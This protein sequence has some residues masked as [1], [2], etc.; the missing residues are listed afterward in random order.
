MGDTN[1]LRSDMKLL[2]PHLAVFA[3]ITV[4]MSKTGRAKCRICGNLIQKG[5]I[6]VGKIMKEKVSGGN[7]MREIQRWLHVDCYL[8]VSLTTDEEKVFVQRKRKQ[9]DGKELD[10][11]DG[12]ELDMATVGLPNGW[13]DLWLSVPGNTEENGYTFDGTRNTLVTS[14][15][16]RSRLDRMYF[17]LA[18]TDETV[19]CVFDEIA[20]VGQ[21][22]ITDGIWPSDHFGLLG[23]FDIRE[24]DEKRD[25][26]D[27]KAESKKAKRT[28]SSSHV[29]SRHSPISIE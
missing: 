29:G 10:K 28:K 5:V 20:I 27:A 3:D 14:R 9:L 16:F 11:D 17:Y 7:K 25:A 26:H 1:L 24:E 15:S 6:R 21:Q 18:P 8:S 19:R 23:T 22:K 13:K 12:E 4:E 2:D